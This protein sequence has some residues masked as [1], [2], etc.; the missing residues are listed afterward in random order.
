MCASCIHH[1]HIHMLVSVRVWRDKQIAI[2]GALRS[3]SFLLQDCSWARLS[4]ASR[5]QYNQRSLLADSPAWSETSR[6]RGLSPLTLC[7]SLLWAPRSFSLTSLCLHSSSPTRL[8]PLLVQGAL[9]PLTRSFPLSSAQL[10][11]IC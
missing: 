2:P 3:R 9:W 10:N 11:C 6:D 7:P 4:N 5:T 1:I 8:A